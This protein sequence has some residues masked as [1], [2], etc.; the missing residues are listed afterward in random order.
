[1][2]CLRIAE[3]T[4]EMTQNIGATR[5]QKGRSRRDG[6]AE[7]R[8]ISTCEKDKDYSNCERARMGT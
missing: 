7:A 4:H 5:R 1:M 3:M 2:K 6:L 8:K